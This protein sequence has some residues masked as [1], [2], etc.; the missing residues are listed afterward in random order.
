M[1]IKQKAKP[2]TPSRCAC[3]EIIKDDAAFWG[4]C[5]RCRHELPIHSRSVST[6][7]VAHE[8]AYHGDLYNRGEW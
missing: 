6:N 1:D 4:E 3:G 5:E 8:N 2:R 7:S